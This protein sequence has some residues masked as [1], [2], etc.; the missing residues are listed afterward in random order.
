MLVT[1]MCYRA[2]TRREM[3]ERNATQQE[4]Q[5]QEEQHEEQH[6]SQSHAS[7]SAWA[8]PVVGQ[9]E[10]GM[11]DEDMLSLFD[12]EMDSSLLGGSSGPR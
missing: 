7:A 8:S 4:Q 3:W 10:H 2:Q 1:A 9:I 5:Q 6:E 11:E 12:F